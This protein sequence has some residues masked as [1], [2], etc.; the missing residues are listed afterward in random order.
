MQTFIKEYLEHIIPVTFCLKSGNEISQIGDG[1]PE[2]T[3]TFNKD[4][5]QK[6]LLTSTS[7]ALGE[8]Y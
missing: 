3:V 5:D 7:L 6:A 1:T 4:P 2:F 8:A